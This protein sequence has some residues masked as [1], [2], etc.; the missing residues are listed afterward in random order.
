MTKLLGLIM[1]FFKKLFGNNESDNET[2]TVEVDNNETNV[3]VTD[4]EIV[5]NEES[6]IEDEIEEPII[7]RNTKYHILIDNGHGNNTPGKRSPYSACGALP[8]LDYYEYKW[9]REMAVMI[10]DEL[11]KLGYDAERIVT[12][13]TDIT[14]GERVRRVNKV[15]DKYGKNNVIL[16]SI[17]SNAAGSGANW[18]TARGWSA[19]TTRGNTKSDMLCEYL[20]EEAAKNFKG[21]T[22][23]TDKTDGDSDIEADFYVIKNTKC[24]A[25]LSENFFHDN[26]EDVRFLLSQEGK[27][28]IMR[29]H[30]DGIINYIKNN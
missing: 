7:T 10:V 9:A 28:K 22:I 15:C 17:H 25:V 16:I 26:A 2:T 30:V 5:D 19:Y 8:Q 13:E 27:E 29:T 11:V 1:S 18:T 4:V 23:R 6:N 14:L 12:E 20:Y 24:P 21:M 3:D